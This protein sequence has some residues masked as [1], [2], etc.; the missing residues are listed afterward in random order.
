MVNFVFA[1]SLET[2]S[3][4]E[5]RSSETNDLKYDED[6]GPEADLYIIKLFFW[7]WFDETDKDFAKQTLFCVIVYCYDLSKIIGWVAPTRIKLK[8]RLKQCL[9]NNYVAPNFKPC[10]KISKFT[11]KPSFLIL[12]LFYI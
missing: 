11:F 7:A 4:I 12:D 1:D 5:S 2:K 9:S 10:L 6:P 8:S 3:V